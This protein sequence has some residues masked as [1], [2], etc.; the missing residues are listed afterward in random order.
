MKITIVSVGGG[1][2]HVANR[3]R[4][5]DL[6]VEAQLLV[7]DTDVAAL[8]EFKSHA[9]ERFLIKR[10]SE[11][12]TKVKPD[13]MGDLL[14]RIGYITILCATLG[15]LTGS[16]YA[17]IIA[18]E[19]RR[20]GKF[21]CS[22]F[23]M[24]WDFEGEERNRRAT[25]ARAALLAASNLAIQQNNDRLRAAMNGR[26]SMY[27]FMEDQGLIDVLKS[28]LSGSRT[29]EEWATVSNQ[30]NLQALIP[31]R[32]RLPCEPYIEIHANGYSA[33]AE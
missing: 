31:E 14:E 21:V 32:Y 1:G 27:D 17:P 28:V 4:K 24:P 7:C 2:Y 25:A 30:E 19:A 22:L 6:F 20:A 23:A 9:D 16:T 33:K 18:Q 29:L 13:D 3:V 15:G 5:S 12:E 26:C 10:D 11:Q 8:I